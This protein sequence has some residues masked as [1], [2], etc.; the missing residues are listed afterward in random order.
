MRS[1]EALWTELWSAAEASPAPPKSALDDFD[2]VFGPF[3]TAGLDLD[4]TVSRSPLRADIENAL[5]D[6][7]PKPGYDIIDAA[8]V[9]R[10]AQRTLEDSVSIRQLIEE[11][12]IRD[13]F[14]VAW[15][16]TK[17]YLTSSRAS[18]AAGWPRL[19]RLSGIKNVGDEHLSE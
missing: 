3:A 1:H 7:G 14:A 5:R 18:V 6:R 9:Q 13:T 17:G 8:E 2:A 12:T 11:G 16:L 10:I 4:E 19:G 15:L